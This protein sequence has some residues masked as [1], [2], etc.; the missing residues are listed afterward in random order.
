MYKANKVKI[1]PSL[2]RNFFWTLLI[3]V[4]VFLL[5]VLQYYV[6]PDNEI[7]VTL[8][9]GLFIF[10]LIPVTLL[11]IVDGISYL[12]PNRFKSIFSYLFFIGCVYGI[13][14]L[15]ELM[16]TKPVPYFALKI[17]IFIHLIIGIYLLFALTVN[18]VLESMAQY[19]EKLPK[20]LAWLIMVLVWLLVYQL[21]RSV[22]EQTTIVEWLFK[23]GEP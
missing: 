16:L 19:L 18:A 6:I 15:I 2:Q 9:I 8:M 20:Y 22:A 3:W 7:I 4:A 5:F 23:L 10:L 1:P 13:G 11:A 17:V 21:F 12:L 14:F